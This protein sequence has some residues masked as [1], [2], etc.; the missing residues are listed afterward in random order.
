MY[1]ITLAQKLN[2]Y[3]K[4]LFQRVRQQRVIVNLNLTEKEKKNSSGKNVFK[5]K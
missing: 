1:G 2:N 5:I 3:K 4:N